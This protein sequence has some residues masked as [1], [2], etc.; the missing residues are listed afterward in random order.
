MKTSTT[1][2]RNSLDRLRAEQIQSFSLLRNL[3]NVKKNR[4][5]LKKQCKYG[6][7]KI[8]VLEEEIAHAKS[9]VQKLKQ[10]PVIDHI[11]HQ[12]KNIK[13]LKSIIYIYNKGELFEGIRP[14][15]TEM[16]NALILFRRG[17]N[18][19]IY[20]RHAAQL[21]QDI[22]GRSEN[23]SKMHEQMA[24]LKRNYEKCVFSIRS[25]REELSEIAKVLDLR[26]VV[27]KLVAP[28]LITN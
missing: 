23:K 14:D 18:S 6:Y 25:L 8:R 5:K 17:L 7:E 1:D 24:K 13:F 11:K 22:R 3:E 20:L 4:Q 10:K 27:L 19:S 12:D 16:T 9:L 21:L 2:V 26:K 28:N 15:L